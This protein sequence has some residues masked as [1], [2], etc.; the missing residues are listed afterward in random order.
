MVHF[1]IEPTKNSM[2]LLFYTSK[3]SEI[4]SDDVANDDIGRNTLE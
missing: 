1:K 2:K 4:E 3:F